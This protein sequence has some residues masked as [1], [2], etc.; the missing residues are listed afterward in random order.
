MA[1]QHVCVGG[2]RML[3]MDMMWRSCAKLSG[4]PSKWRI[5]P[6]ALLPRPSKAKASKVS[7][8]FILV[9]FCKV[10]HIQYIPTF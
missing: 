5:N 6:H 1:N 8:V 2:T 9:F 4:R 10:T 3:W 7:L